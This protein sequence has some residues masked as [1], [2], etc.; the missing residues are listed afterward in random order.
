MLRQLANDCCSTVH[1][2]TFLIKEAKCTV[3]HVRTLCYFTCTWCM[4]LIES[5]A[6]VTVYVTM[7]FTCL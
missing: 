6:D 7:G 3:Y 4:P 5:C 2:G 1:L